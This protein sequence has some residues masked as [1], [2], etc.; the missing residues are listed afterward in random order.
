VLLVAMVDDFILLIRRRELAT[1]PAD[2]LKAI[3]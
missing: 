3:E 2:E 1:A